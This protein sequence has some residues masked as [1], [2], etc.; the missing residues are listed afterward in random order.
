MLSC[1]YHSLTRNSMLP[2]PYHPLILLLQERS[3]CQSNQKGDKLVGQALLIGD[4]LIGALPV[5][6]EC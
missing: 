5:P 2:C 3:H 6:E 1:P 4:L